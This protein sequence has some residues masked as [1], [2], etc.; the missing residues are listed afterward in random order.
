MA[1]ALDS[2][3]QPQVTV[4]EFLYSDLPSHSDTP[5]CL[6]QQDMLTVGGSAQTQDHSTGPS[7]PRDGKGKICVFR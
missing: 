4:Q 5:E 1:H 6:A 3:V 7:P 2:Y